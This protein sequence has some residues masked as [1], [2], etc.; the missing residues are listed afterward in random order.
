MSELNNTSFAQLPSFAAHKEII[1]FQTTREGGFSEE[2]YSSL[3]LSY[4]TGDHPDIILKNR[5]LLAQIIGIPLQNFVVARQTHSAN[6]RVVTEQ[7]RGC[8]VWF[9]NKEALMDFDALITDTPQTVLCISTADCIPILL[10]DPVKHVIAAVH[11]G[12]K[13]TAQRIAMQTVIRMIYHYGC[14]VKDICA[15]IMVGAGGCCYEVDARVAD[16]MRTSL[17]GGNA[18][19]TLPLCE[20][21]MCASLPCGDV[22]GLPADPYLIAKP[23]GKYNVDLK[24]MNRLQLLRAGL[25]PA[26][27]EIHPAC[28]ICS[29][30]KYFSFRNSDGFHFGQSFTCIAMR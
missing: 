17:L 16:A 8:G 27:I 19:R 25:L 5:L 21:A 24:Q 3:N 4:W 18:M 15:G 10:Y 7:D 23:L 26:N 2:P 9:D 29:P 22:S 1:H 14:C 12:W 20:D 6:V 30:Q 28:T 13:G 11:A